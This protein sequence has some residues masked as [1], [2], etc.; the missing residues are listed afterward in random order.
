MDDRS[1]DRYTRF[2]ELNFGEELHAG[3]AKVSWTCHDSK[4]TIND[5]ILSWAAV[6]GSLTGEGNPVF[7]VDDEPIRVTLAAGTF[8]KARL[9]ET[10][11]DQGFTG[12]YTQD[13]SIP[14][15][16]SYGGTAD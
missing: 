14:G 15:R 4:L 16:I 1:A 3:I 5:L 7:S 11:R 8:R 10:L 6:L 12:I 9:D 2:L 13:V